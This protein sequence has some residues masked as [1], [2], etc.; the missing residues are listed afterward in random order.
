MDRRSFMRGVA[1]A[2]VIVGGAIVTKVKTE[3][4][5]PEDMPMKGEAP[6]G[7]ERISSETGDPG[8]RAFAMAC[9]DGKNVKIYLDGVGQKYATMADAREGLVKRLVLTPEGNMA[10]NRVTNEMFTEIVS[11]WV[12]IV[13]A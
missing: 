8:E 4:I 12:A 3:E 2:P 6:K 13:L 7:Y 1:I 10:F 5:T 11:G 9:G